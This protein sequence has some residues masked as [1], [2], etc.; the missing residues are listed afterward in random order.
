MFQTMLGIVLLFADLFLHA[1]TADNTSCHD[2][3]DGGKLV[4]SGW[5]IIEGGVDRYVFSIDGG[6]TWADCGLY[7]RNTIGVAGDAYLDAAILNSGGSYVFEDREASRANA[8]YQC[9]I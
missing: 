8:V 9:N 2:C 6:K 7:N 4:I 1:G 5:T 3:F